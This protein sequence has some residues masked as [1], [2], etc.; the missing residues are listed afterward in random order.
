MDDDRRPGVCW[1]Q[2]P[3]RYPGAV[4]ICVVLLA[5]ALLACTGG[6]GRVLELEA[7]ARSLEASLEALA[8]E[9]AE[10]KGEIAA[11]RERLDDRD[12]RLQELEE[13]ASKAETALPLQGAVVQGQ[14]RPAGH[15][16]GEDRQAGGGVRR[17]GPLRRPPRPGGLGPC[18][19]FGL[20]RTAETPLIVS[21][22][23]FGGD[24]AYQSAYVPLHERVNSDG[25]ALL[26]PNGQ[27]DGQGNRFWNPTDECCEGGKTGD[28]DVAYLTGLIATCTEDRGLR[29]GVLL[30]LL[31]RRVHG[32]PHG[33]QGTARPS[34]GGQPGRYELRR[35]LQLRRRAPGVRAALSTAPRTT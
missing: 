12:A 22:H 6:D 21:L 3:V 29:A 11:L 2:A 34:R 20:R 33:L 18:D 24:S 27:L 23:G 28:D 30:R 16:R 8:D 1:G 25:F 31:Q 15:S 26:L 4:A 19:A 35:G 17:R 10:L 9:N 32:A 13:A 14:G 7:K 5:A